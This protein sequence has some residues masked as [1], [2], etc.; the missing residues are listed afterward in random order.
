M[1]LNSL[2]VLA[3]LVIFSAACPFSAA[4]TPANPAIPATATLAPALPATSIPA[5]S[6]PTISQATTAATVASQTL[7]NGPYLVFLRDRGNGQE[8]VLMDANGK[9][10]TVFPFP[11]N[12]NIYSSQSLS[13]LVSPDG[14]WLAF[15]TGSAGPAF[16]QVGPNTADLTLNLMS[17]GITNPAGSKKV[18][19]RLLSAD[20]PANFAQ[21]ARELGIANITAQDLQNAFVS[22]IS[23][24]IAWSPDGL[25]LAFAG[26]MDGFSSDLYLYQDAFGTIQR[27]S[28]GPEEVQW[29][30]WSPDGKWIL[31]GS[32]YTVGEGM[33]YN[34]YAT[35]L[36]GKVVKR[37]LEDTSVAGDLTWINATGFLA[38]QSQ[39]GPGDF[40]LE[41]VDIESGKVDKIWA[42]SFRSA[43]LAVDQTGNWLTLQ[44]AEDGLF[45]VDLATLKLTKV[46][47]PDTTH[48]YGTRQDILSMSNGPERTFLTRD[49]T[50]LGL[51]YL[52]TNGAMT[53]AGT[54]AD[55]FSVSPNQV[56]WI[57]IQDDIQLFAAGSSQA[58]TFNLPAGTNRN[59][60]GRI[61]WRPD[62]SGIFLVS[63]TRQLYALDFSSGIS[64]L[65][66]PSLSAANPEVFIWI[67]K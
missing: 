16:G 19:S 58:R 15:Y 39:N 27:L 63:N 57:A 45:L 41:R 32:S 28:S 61:L 14:I 42:G 5:T 52:S 13:N 59:D 31:D 34:L 66:D 54:S 49:D 67:R 64:T 33:T 48:D 4:V 51:Y 62:S 26:Q 12:N 56:D 46:Q 3:G 2:I 38:Y 11:I 60:F 44:T 21:A 22:G 8:L 50:S 9:G 23:Q 6:L 36:D 7:T 37:L 24:S 47:V 10:A 35:S 40:G 53:S 65:V 18:I 20:Y 55:L 30:T 25:H 29:I 43:S 1:K 17:L